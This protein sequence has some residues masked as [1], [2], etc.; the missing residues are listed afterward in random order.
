M[1]KDNKSGSGWHGSSHISDVQYDPKD[2]CLTVH[3]LVD[4]YRYHGVTDGDFAA[5]SQ[6]DS[7]GSHLNKHVISRVGKDIRITKLTAD[8]RGAARFAKC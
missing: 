6:A 7:P 1:S 5:L 3:F 8:E 4:S 2:Q